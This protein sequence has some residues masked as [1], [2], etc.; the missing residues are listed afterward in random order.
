MKKVAND[1]VLSGPLPRRLRSIWR[2]AFARPR[3]P[4]PKRKR[5][6]YRALLRNEPWALELK[7]ERQ[8][9]KDFIK[10]FLS[11]DSK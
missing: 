7:A 3:P 10:N 2:G 5:A 8:K 6:Y 1:D 11:E 4:E 9:M